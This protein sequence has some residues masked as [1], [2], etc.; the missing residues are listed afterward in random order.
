[1]PGSYE[2]F[3]EVIHGR[4]RFICE[5][6]TREIQQAVLCSFHELNKKVCRSDLIVPHLS[7]EWEVGFEF[8]IAE[9]MGFNYL[10]TGELE[11]LKKHLIKKELPTMDFFCAVHYHTINENGK[12]VPLRF[13]YHLMRFTFH[14]KS[15]ELLV[16]HERG[17]QHV[18]LHDF[19]NFIASYINEELAKEHLKPLNLEYLRTL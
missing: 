16:H 8:G 7:Q 12:R 3:P 11:R 4:A 13:D 18:P 9:G 19:I 6:S 1:M 10:D 15:V 14:G 17:S 5:G 2:N